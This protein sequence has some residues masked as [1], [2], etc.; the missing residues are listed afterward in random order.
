MRLCQVRGL[1][2]RGHGG[3]LDA[4]SRD[5][6]ERPGVQRESEP[7]L[8][9]CRPGELD[10]AP[11][12]Q[13][14]PGQV[15]GQEGRV[16]QQDLSP[17]PER[18][19]G[20]AGQAP[21]GF[22]FRDHP[23]RV[24]CGPG[25]AGQQVAAPG[26]QLRLPGL[27]GTGYA[28]GGERGGPPVVTQVIRRPGRAEHHPGQD[29]RSRRGRDAGRCSQELARFAVPAGSDP[30]PGEPG[31]QFPPRLRLGAAQRPG[32]RGADAGLSGGK[33]TGPVLPLGARPGRLCRPGYLQRP[34]QQP[35]VHRRFLAGCGQLAGGELADGLQQRITDHHVGLDLHE[36]LAGQAGQQPG[37]RLRRHRL[38]TGDPL[39]H[40]KVESA[41]QHRQPGQQA[42]FGLIEQ[43]I[44][45]G[46]QGLQGAVPSRAGGTAGQQARVALQPGSELRGPE[47]RAPGCG[48]LDG[49]RHAVQP[50]AHLGDRG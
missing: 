9:R 8:A 15:A 2:E 17:R 41:A 23:V 26:F 27:P 31:S 22:D 16:G 30:P 37:D 7:F 4:R 1:V 45:P 42:P 40:V 48:Q 12:V 29:A 11:A 20:R 33:P 39:G 50:G 10:R 25:Q 34:P 46:H 47:R 49:Q 13:V 19:I 32:Q 21:A 18:R 36:R 44:A 35:G 43:L 38:A 5:R 24:A 28:V 14:L 6:G 3:G